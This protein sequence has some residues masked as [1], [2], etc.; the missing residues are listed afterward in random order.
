MSINLLL[1]ALS[2]S[3]LVQK[4]AAVKLSD[5]RMCRLLSVYSPNKAAVSGEISSTVDFF[6]KKDDEHL[7]K[8]VQI[9]DA[10]LT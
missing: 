6:L 1:S 3:V 7:S 8:I 2:T 5:N 9:F 4:P 10:A